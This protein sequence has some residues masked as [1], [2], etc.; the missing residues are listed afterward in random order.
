[1]FAVALRGAFFRLIIINLKQ[2][3]RELSLLVGV[4]YEMER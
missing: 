2:Y 3:I 1:M 4:T